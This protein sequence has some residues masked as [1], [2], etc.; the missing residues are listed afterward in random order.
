[1]RARSH[2]AFNAPALEMF[3]L[4]GNSIGGTIPDDLFINSVTV[5]QLNLGRNDLSG[6]ISGGFGELHM[7]ERLMLNANKFTGTIPSN[8]G[9]LS[10]LGQ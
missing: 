1:M 7:L 3:D 9:L 8:F 4:E 2:E 5:K 10:N 6:T